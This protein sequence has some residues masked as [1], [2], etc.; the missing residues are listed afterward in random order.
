MHVSEQKNTLHICSMKQVHRRKTDQKLIT[1]LFAMFQYQTN[2]L[3]HWGAILD[4]CKS[5]TSHIPQVQQ[6][7]INTKRTLWRSPMKYGAK[8]VKRSSSIL[9]K[10]HSQISQVSFVDEPVGMHLLG[11]RQ[12]I[13]RP[14]HNKYNKVSQNSNRQTLDLSLYTCN[15]N[16]P[17]PYQD[18]I[19]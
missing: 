4:G 13:N 9:K 12:K 17:L 2:G 15:N 6:K 19:H 8:K 11:G 1:H 18:C 10:I 14:L 5:A 3:W 7:G 16:L